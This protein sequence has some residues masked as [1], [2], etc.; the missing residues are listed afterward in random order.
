[1]TVTLNELG[2]R[3]LIDYQ[4]VSRPIEGSAIDL[5]GKLNKESLA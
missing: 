4:S 3:Q 5:L 2:N 1:M